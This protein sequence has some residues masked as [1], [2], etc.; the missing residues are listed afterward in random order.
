MQ[1]EFLQ[2]ITLLPRLGK[3]RFVEW[4]GGINL[5]PLQEPASQ[6]DFSFKRVSK[7]IKENLLAI[8]WLERVYA[9]IHVSA[10]TAIRSFFNTKDSD[11]QSSEMLSGQVS[12]KRIS[13]VLNLFG[14]DD[15]SWI[16]PFFKEFGVRSIFHV[17][18]KGDRGFYRDLR[19]ISHIIF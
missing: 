7:R 1:E 13:T 6:V 4:T 3:L 18:N 5:N 15:F 8:Q 11:D 10:D 14:E 12:A 9:V 17:V 19:R 2:T 16:E